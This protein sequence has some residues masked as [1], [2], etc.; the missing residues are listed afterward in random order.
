M[1]GWR[2]QEGAAI[3][4]SGPYQEAMPVEGGLVARSQGPLP[5][6]LT[7][8]TFSAHS[9]GLWPGPTLLTRYLITRSEYMHVQG[10]DG[11]DVSPNRSTS[12]CVRAR[13]PGPLAGDDT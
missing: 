6:C 8:R 12:C 10:A 7:H 9:L 2:E 11:V 5:V 13:L 1:P 3:C 4:L